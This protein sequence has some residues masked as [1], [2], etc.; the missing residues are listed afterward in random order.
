[1]WLRAMS[2]IGS[3]SQ[4]QSESSSMGM[5]VTDFKTSILT[6][7]CT[8]VVPNLGYVPIKWKEWPVD[9]VT[10]LELSLIRHFLPTW[11]K[12]GRKRS[13]RRA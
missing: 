9:V 8:H 10:S 6:I 4:A 5:G 1:L 11:T 3:P 13:E 7:R 12:T 2:R